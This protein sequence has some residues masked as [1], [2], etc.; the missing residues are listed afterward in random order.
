M[1]GEVQLAVATEVR[2]NH[3]NV[4]AQSSHM[5]DP[6]VLTWHELVDLFLLCFIEFVFI[7]GDK[8]LLVIVQIWNIFSFTIVIV[9]IIGG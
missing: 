8:V 9:I 6:S 7:V 5:T 3:S 4:L 2:C 1:I